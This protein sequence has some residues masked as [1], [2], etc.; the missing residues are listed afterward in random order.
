[1]RSPA[2]P[3]R[4]PEV[5]APVRP[6]LP[7]PVV[8]LRPRSRQRALPAFPWR[9]RG[10][11]LHFPAEASRRIGWELCLPPAVERLPLAAEHH[12]QAPARR[13]RFQVQAPSPALPRR[14]A[15]RVWVQALARPPAPAQA[16]AVLPAA[17][18]ASGCGSG[19]GWPPAAAQARAVP[20]AAAQARAAPP[21]A[22]QA[23]AV[24]L[25]A[26]QVRAALRW[27]AGFGRGLRLRLRLRRG[28]CLRLRFGA[29]AGCASGCGSGAG[30]TS[31]CGSGAGCA[32]G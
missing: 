18:C 30:C 13:G 5:A 7:E 22:A 8:R 23:W 16:R 28:L 12:R 24:P 9:C 4:Q 15:Q 14:P 6:E 1:M 2:R 20:P 26:A 21:A 29:G 27:A 32:S 17:G 11:A 25:A 10:Q 31:G 3:C 19:A